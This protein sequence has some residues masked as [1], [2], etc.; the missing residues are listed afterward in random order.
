[1]G[2]NCKETR[3]GERKVGWQDVMK[4]HKIKLTYK[5]FILK[6]RIFAK[7]IFYLIRISSAFKVD[8]SNSLIIWLFISALFKFNSKYRISNITKGTYLN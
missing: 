8:V 4:S 3:K 5:E 2:I 6:K 7:R 1:M